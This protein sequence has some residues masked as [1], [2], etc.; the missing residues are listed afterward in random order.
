M[1]CKI[2]GGMGASLTKQ[3]NLFRG[4][5]CS[6]SIFSSFVDACRQD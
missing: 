4:D 6:S 2:N 3:E 1:L 5:E